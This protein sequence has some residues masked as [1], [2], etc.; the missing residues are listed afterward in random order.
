MT[1]HRELRSNASLWARLGPAGRIGFVALALIFAACLGS[2]P[3]T[4]TSASGSGPPTP[5]FNA[6]TTAEALRPPSWSPLEPAKF[7]GTDVL[8]RSLFIRCLTG[9]GAS[10]SIGLLAA[11]ISVTI[12]TLWGSIAAFAGGRIDAFMMRT[13]D[14]LYGLPY[15]LLVVLLAVATGLVI[16]AISN[17]VSVVITTTPGSRALFP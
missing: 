15:I 11:A 5:R 3:W 16:E 12:G 8:G 17:T 14:V 9:G 2:L 10:L 13:V 7:W 4:L 6:G 1:E